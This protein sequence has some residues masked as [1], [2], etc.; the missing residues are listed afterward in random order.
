MRLRA[1]TRPKWDQVN[2]PTIK[3]DARD[4][5][6]LSQILWI[7][8]YTFGALRVRTRAASD[9]QL[10]STRASRRVA[11]CWTTDR[12]IGALPPRGCKFNLPAHVHIVKASALV[13]IHRANISTPFA[14]SASATEWLRP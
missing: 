3:L 12:V 7:C 6:R 1:C 4:L 2:W 5:A 13:E 9:A 11:D 10:C 14:G 8:Q